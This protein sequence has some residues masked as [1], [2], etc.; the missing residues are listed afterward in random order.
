MRA[1]SSG[2]FQCFVLNGTRV[3]KGEILALV[4]DPYGKYEKQIKASQTGYVICINEAPV[5]YKGDAI[6]HLAK[7]KPQL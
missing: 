2:M 3:Q 6:I 7:E 5:V 1:P 4:T